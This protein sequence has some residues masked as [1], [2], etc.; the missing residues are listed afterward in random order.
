TY[1]ERPPFSNGGYV[2]QDIFVFG[3]T[4]SEFLRSDLFGVFGYIGAGRCWG[5]IK[6]EKSNYSEQSAH[7]SDYS[8]GA[9]VLTMESSITTKYLSVRFGHSLLTGRAASDSRSSNVAWPFTVFYL[10]LSA[11]IFSENRL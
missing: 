9:F 2:D 7:R 11:P 8:I 4:G 6:E 5:Y 1:L 3:Q 10:S